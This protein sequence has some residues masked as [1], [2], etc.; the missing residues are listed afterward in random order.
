MVLDGPAAGNPLLQTS[1][2]PS[3][4]SVRG[5]LNN[6]GGG[7]TAWGTVFTAEENFDQYFGNSAALTAEKR[8]FYSRLAAPAGA[9]ERKW[10]RFHDRF[11]LGKEPNEYAKFGLGGTIRVSASGAD[12]DTADTLTYAWTASDGG[13]F[14]ASTLAS[15]ACTCAT[16]GRH[17]L[18]VTVSDGNCLGTRAVP[19]AC[20]P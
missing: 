4:R 6:C 3:G 1:T 2:G 16:V 10:E 18:T 17:T 9:S 15:T 14:A 20:T 8:T 5:T 7:L 19:I 11:D 13:A 12:V